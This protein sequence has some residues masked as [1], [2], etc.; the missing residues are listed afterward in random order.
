MYVNVCM[1]VCVYVCMYVCVYVCMYVCIYI[2]VC[3]Y[4]CI[5][6]FPNRI[7]HV[8]QKQSTAAAHHLLLCSWPVRL[9]FCL[10]PN[11]SSSIQR[12]P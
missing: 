12:S 10:M 5:S 1:C 9:G 6:V 11:A 7:E 4:V 3:M 8:K 2:H